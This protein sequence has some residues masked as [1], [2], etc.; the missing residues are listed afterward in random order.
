MRRTVNL[1]R[2]SPRRAYAVGLVRAKR[3]SRREMHQMALDYDTELSDL[4]HRFRE[5]AV[6]Y[7]R[8]RVEAAIDEAIIERSDR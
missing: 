6:E 2:L 8:T 3:Q 5:L 7:H 4:E 1:A